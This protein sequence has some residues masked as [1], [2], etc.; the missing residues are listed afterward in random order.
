MLFY[1]RI[2]IEFVPLATHREYIYT[3]KAP[4]LS[5]TLKRSVM[6]D[7]TAPRVSRISIKRQLTCCFNIQ[8]R[9]YFTC[10]SRNSSRKHP[11]SSA[12]RLQHSLNTSQSKQAAHAEYKH[13]H[14]TPPVS[15][16]YLLM[17][18]APL[19]M[20]EKVGMLTLSRF[21]AQTDGRS[22]LQP[23][24]SSHMLVCL[25]AGSL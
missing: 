1:L 10:S 15:L 22:E 17:M 11:S 25:Q 4:S 12:T 16:F 8:Q 19:Y 3:H 9:L 21:S 13:I 6:T 20:T 5:N 7:F 18:T 2:D 24:A 14:H 23:S